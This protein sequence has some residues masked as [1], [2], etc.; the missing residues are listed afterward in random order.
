[1]ALIFF[2]HLEMSPPEFGGD[3]DVALE[4]YYHL[5]KRIGLRD[6]RVL[7]QIHGATIVGADGARHTKPI[8]PLVVGEGDAIWTSEPGVWVGVFTADCLPILLDADDRVMAVH[9]GWRSLAAGI[10]EKAVVFLG[11][12]AAIRAATVGSAAMKCCYEVGD[13]V[14]A[15]LRLAG[16]EPIVEGRNLDMVETAEAELRRLGVVTIT[17]SEP[18]GCTICDKRFHS[19][20]RDRDRAG[21]SLS[22]I[23]LE[24]RE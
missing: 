17:R 5:A 3:F 19:F 10:I 1:M 20:R 23:A 7:K 8:L 2:E 6:G 13:E 21:R 24:R 22:G 12:G 16:I 9:A 18:H 4:N 14:V 15:A 11:N